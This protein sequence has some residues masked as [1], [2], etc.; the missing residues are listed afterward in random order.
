ML[1]DF[2]AMISAGAGLAGIALALRRISRGRLPR[3]TLPALIALGMLGYSIWSEYSWYGR[4]SAALPA[5]VTVVAR[6]QD[7][8]P[9]RP[10][11]LLAP[12]TLRFAAFDGTVLRRSEQNPA[13]RTAEVMLVRRWAAVTRVPM[14]FDCA[15][16]TQAALIEGATVAPDGTLTG[17]AWAAA[18]PGDALQDAACKEG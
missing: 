18:A 2:L 7:R 14:A 4:V 6:A 13:I 16:G 5:G 3:W 8:Q 15:A 11:T 12:L 10:W 9:W 17:A 1:W